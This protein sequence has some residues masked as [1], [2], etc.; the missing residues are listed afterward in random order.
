MAKYSA[1]AAVQQWPAVGL[2]GPHSGSQRPSSSDLAARLGG[3][4]FVLV[5]DEAD[6]RRAAD[7][8]R[9]VVSALSE[10]MQAGGEAVRIGC[11]VGLAFW[12]DHGPTA[13][14]LLQ[15]ADKALYLAKGSGKNA[16]VCF[17]GVD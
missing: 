2:A 15:N 3:D 16:V 7:V 5:L 17:D 9:R 14:S 10:P 8:A 6:K 11:S 4:E 13:S 1:S 12:P